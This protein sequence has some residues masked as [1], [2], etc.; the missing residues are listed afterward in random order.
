MMQ[1]NYEFL[2]TY[3]CLDKV[4]CE[5]YSDRKGISSYIDDMKTVSL[6]ES[7]LI[8][9]WNYDLSNLIR[10]RYLRNQLTHECGTWDLDLLTQSDIQWL[11]EFYSRIM[12]QSD[13]L[14]VLRRARKDHQ[15]QPG[16]IGKKQSA[17]VLQTQANATKHRTGDVV[18]R[19]RSG[20]KVVDPIR[21]VCFYIL[22]LLVL[23][24]FV[25]ALINLLLLVL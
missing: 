2:E 25:I 10:L 13:P 4:C 14:S 18:T 11:R 22:F 12:K 3:K 6:Y 17:A 24:V 19:K 7:R 21:K 9:N 8:N 16:I 1:M 23:I 15:A 20:S 5:I